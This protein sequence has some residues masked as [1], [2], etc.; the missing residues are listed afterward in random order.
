LAILSGGDPIK[1]KETHL[2]DDKLYFYVSR[3]N[4]LY[5]H[6][7]IDIKEIDLKNLLLLS[8]TNCLRNQALKFMC[9]SRKKIKMPYNLANCSLETMLQ[10]VD[11]TSSLTI[12][13]GMAIGS[14]PEERRK[15]IRPFASIDA[16]RKITMAVGRNCVRQ[17]LINVIRESIVEVSKE[18][19][20]L[21]LLYG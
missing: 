8:E 7:E 15:Q 3:R 2:F 4:K 14:I 20:V 12:L 1:I 21:N 6:S 9:L 16:H 10:I 11:T 17:S 19:A 5:D 18:Y 13:P